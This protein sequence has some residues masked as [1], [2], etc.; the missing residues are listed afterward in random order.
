MIAIVNI[1]GQQFKVSEGQEIFVN[2]LQAEEGDAV[3]FDE[4]LMTATDNSS[5]IGTP[6]LSG[7]SVKATVIG[8][9]KSDTIL[10]FKKKRRKGYKVKNGHRQPMTKIKIDS[11]A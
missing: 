11:I 5:N 6:T 1:Q 2:K 3:S 8:H 7:T 4:V 10:V 9:V